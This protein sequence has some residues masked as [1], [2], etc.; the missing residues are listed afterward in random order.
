MRHRVA[1]INTLFLKGTL[2]TVKFRQ[3]TNLLYRVIATTS[4][5]AELRDKKELVQRLTTEN[6]D[7]TQDADSLRR[8]LDK[9]EKEV[10]KAQQVRGGGGHLRWS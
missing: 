10:K 3:Y 2:V 4:L 8:R 1:K 7:L 6:G 5:T 9:Y